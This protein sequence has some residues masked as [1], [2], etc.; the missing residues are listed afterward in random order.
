MVWFLVRL[1]RRANQRLKLPA[2]YHGVDDFV[3]RLP[4]L[5][6]GVDII[7]VRLLTLRDVDIIVGHILRPSV[8]SPTV[9]S[10][11]FSIFPSFSRSILVSSLMCSISL[12]SLLCSRFIAELLVRSL[13]AE[14]LVLDI[15]AGLLVPGLFAAAF[16][17]P[18]SRAV[19]RRRPRRRSPQFA[20]S[21]S[22]RASSS[23][24][25]TIPSVVR[26]P[27]LIEPRVVDLVDD[28]LSRPSLT[29]GSAT[30]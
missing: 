4:Q 17:R 12:P 7:V 5:L 19:L 25:S 13:L 21:F 29:D 14:L 20:V 6:P 22:S 16:R 9:F 18:R 23:T 30:M 2:R 28:I 24:L 11:L 1:A 3:G 27:V 26:G 8:A 15:L 10:H